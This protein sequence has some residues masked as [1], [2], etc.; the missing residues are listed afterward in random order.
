MI[1]EQMPPKRAYR[2]Q[3]LSFLGAYVIL[4]AVA[5]RGA[6]GLSPA[7]AY[8]IAVAPALPVGGMVWAMLRYIA[9][10]DEYIRALTAK[11]FIVAS[12]LVYAAATAW[13]FLELYAS[14]PD[15]PLYLIFPVLCGALGLTS[16]L[17]RTSK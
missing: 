7:T 4:L 17:V 10:S 15:F 1:F 9:R 16:L 3:L 13:G 8:F 6:A 14:V 5:E 2:A 12:G 11:R